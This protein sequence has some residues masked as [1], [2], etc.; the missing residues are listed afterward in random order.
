M[1][2]PPDPADRL[3]RLILL[4]YP[5]EYL[6]TFGDE[7]RTTFLDGA[8]EARSQG[9]LVLFLLRELCDIP[10]VLASA[11][12]NGWKRKAQTGIQILQEITSSSDLPPAPPDGRNSWKQVVF[13]CS[14]FIITGILLITATYFPI[15]GVREGWQRSAEYLGK[16]I[17]PCTLPFLLL[18][19]ARGLPRWAYPFSGL[20]LGYYAFVSNQT[21]LGLF[22]LLLLF[23]STLL[24]L[25]VILTNPQ[26]TLLP[27]LFRRIR[28]SVIN[29]LDA[30]FVRGLRSHALA[31]PHGV[32]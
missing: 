16:I 32:R 22:L 6:N 18:G 29:R 11:Y 23:G 13:E 24:A 28:Q 31:Y 25:A 3:Y 27:I 14:L 9:T 17:V 10:K 5:P 20:L 19:L 30:S 2:A 7:M 26:P 8:D 4:A 1:N 15:E 12:W 21:A